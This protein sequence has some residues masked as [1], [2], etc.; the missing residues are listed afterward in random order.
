MD[1][2]TW[3]ADSKDLPPGKTLFVRAEGKNILLVNV[4]GKIYALSNL[5]T[6]SK[7]YLHNGKLK[8][9]VITC[10]C[11]FAEFDVTTGAA[12]AP[13]AKEPLATYPVKVEGTGIWVQA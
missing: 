3:V 9:K 11:H 2:Y 8:G 13:P 12:L 5:C 10:P 1:N 7:C 4:D 6:H